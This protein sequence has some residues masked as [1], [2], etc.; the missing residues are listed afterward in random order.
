[1]AILYD[2]DLKF[3]FLTE[4]AKKQI[5]ASRLCA[6]SLY[7]LI[8]QNTGN[9]YNNTVE[10]RFLKSSRFLEIP[11]LTNVTFPT[12]NNVIIP[13]LFLTFR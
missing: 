1:M 8:S 5:K 10:S 7:C 2:R 6:V 4:K 13:E 9:V 12:P 3:N 11:E